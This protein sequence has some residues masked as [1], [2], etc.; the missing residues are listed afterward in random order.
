MK[1]ESIQE[2]LKYQQWAA[3]LAANDVALGATEPLAVVHKPNGEA[4]FAMLRIT[5][6]APQD[7]T[8]PSIVLL[9]G[10]FV[11]VLTA[12]TEQETGDTYLLLVKQRR[13]ANGAYFYEH[14]SGM[15]DS[16]T[17]PFAVAQK[18]VEEETGLRV[19]RSQLVL[20]T[21]TPLYASPGLLDE[22]G[23]FFYY[24]TTM[25]RAE[26]DAMRGRLHGA[27][28]ENERIELVLAPISEARRL[29]LNA[30]GLLHLFLYQEAKAA[31][32]A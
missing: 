28:D 17:D 23:Y 21:E 11:S 7:Y 24:E 8:L 10:H 29:I 26:L 2:S 31:G 12:I 30:N 6:E 15:C 3:A 14:P 16:T 13:V 25:P 32:K 1:Q 5:A 20:L 19:E 9:R 4:L 27:A 22:A 18:E